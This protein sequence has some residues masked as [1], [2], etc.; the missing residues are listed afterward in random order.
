MSRAPNFFVVGAVKSGTTAMCEYLSRHPDVYIPPEKELNFFG[1]DMDL[2]VPRQSWDEYLAMYFATAGAETRLGDG[3]VWYLYTRAA[4]QEI[5]QRV[6]DARIVIMLRQPVEMLYSLHS[7][8]LYNDDEDLT[9]FQDALSAE[10]AR[11]DGERLPANVTFPEQLHY[12]AIADY[13]PQVERYL[14]VFGSDRVRVI[15]FDD[16]RRETAQVFRDT[17]RFLEID[18]DFTTEL[19][20]INPAKKVRFRPLQNFLLRPPPAVRWIGRKLMPGFHDRNELRRKML[21]ANAGPQTRSPLD[22][23][24]RSDLLDELRPGIRRL[25]DVLG[26]DLS[27]WTQP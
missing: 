5:R 18:P 7:Q 27:S 8:L 24:I 12:R 1:S 15:L 10:S 6:P 17:L 19:E 13:A 16:F 20:V 26:K 14:E 11:R 21:A 4:A 3:S 25:E 23:T 9:S 22:P 2:R